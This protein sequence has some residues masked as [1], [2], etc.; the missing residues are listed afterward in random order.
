MRY[1]ITV[2]RNGR[3]ARNFD[4]LGDRWPWHGSE[5]QAQVEVARL[6]RIDRH[7]SYDLGPSGLEYSYIE[8]TEL[9]SQLLGRSLAWATRILCA[10]YNCVKRGLA[11]FSRA[12]DA[13]HDARRAADRA[14][15]SRQ[16]EW[17]EARGRAAERIG[18][19]ALD[20][21]G[22]DADERD[23]TPEIRA[24]RVILARHGK[25]YAYYIPWVMVGRPNLLVRAT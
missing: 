10:H 9:L 22:A 13:A 5:E 8:E 3:P 25:S 16:A 19:A 2:T 14:T 23:L 6:A 21:I 15:T 17:A 12:A 1:Y 24:A 20:A 4:T 7:N 11:A 18:V